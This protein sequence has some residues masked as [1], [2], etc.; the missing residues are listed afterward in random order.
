[1]SLR[2]KSFLIF[3]GYWQFAI[4]GLHEAFPCTALP[5]QFDENVLGHMLTLKVSTKRT[6]SKR[7]VRWSEILSENN[8]Q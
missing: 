5:Q 7:L 3:L 8:I 4:P 6:L 1:M 2:Y